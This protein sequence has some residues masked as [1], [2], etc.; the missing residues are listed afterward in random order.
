[1]AKATTL[2]LFI[3]FSFSIPAQEKASPADA[4]LAAAYK[5][6]GEQHKNVFVIFHASW[7]GWC[8]KMDTSINNRA[9]KKMFD[10]N[11]VIVH[12]AVHESNDKKK[13]ENPGAADI[14]KKYHAFEEGVPFW[15]VYDK[16][17]KLLATSLM[18]S[19]EGKEANIGCPA[20]EAEVAAFINILQTTSS[21]SNKELSVIAT[22]FRK[23]NSK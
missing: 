5:Q 1:M 22:V 12:L 21:L 20:S 19:A 14:L 2:F 9:C 8:K 17:A 10:D 16:N 23:N 15:L 13:E 18:K 7:C 11:Y 3:L 4:I 6:A